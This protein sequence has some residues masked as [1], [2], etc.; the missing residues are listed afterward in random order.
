MSAVI[1]PWIERPLRELLKQ[2]GH[3]W[4]I[5]G[6]S[7]LGQ[8]ELARALSKAWLCE[9]VTPNGACGVCPSCHTFES[10]TNPD[11]F[12]LMPEEF[13]LHHGYTLDEKVQKEL[14]DK[15][16][17]PSRE[18]KVDQAR[19]LIEFSQM[20]RSG[21]IGKV[22]LVYPAE[23][24]N[25]ITAN[26]ILKTLEEPPEG[27]RFVLATQAAHE[28]LPTIR[29]RCQ[30]YTLSWPTRE[31]SLA[32]LT[33]QGLQGSD[34]LVWLKA[35]GGRPQNALDLAQHSG[36]SAKDWG[37]IP[38]SVASGEVSLLT[39]LQ[40]SEMVDV[41]QKLCHDMLALSVGAEGLFFDTQSLPK[42][43]NFRALSDWSRDLM[44]SA[45]SA[46]HPFNKG[47][48]LET[49]VSQAKIA[50]TQAS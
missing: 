39:Q 5:L 13:M 32:W 2:V 22:A 40:A 24:M 38:K 26:T 45:Q 44:H 18:I 4:L 41:L 7:G 15:K 27:F 49:L 29:S 50:M 8:Y 42:P 25:T 6:P 21:G 47:L 31:E 30:S 48:M 10:Q 14:D 36:L 28:L 23:R 34:A 33:E 1:G 35:A 16:R 9:D 20:T 43:G 46:D 3:A 11:L 19:D 17:K 12:N 37:K